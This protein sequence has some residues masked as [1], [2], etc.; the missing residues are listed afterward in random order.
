ML[1][2]EYS[3]QGN[4]QGSEKTLN[5]IELA[6]TD[7]VKKSTLLKDYARCKICGRR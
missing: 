1:S 7:A 5:I 4:K 3:K 6:K 2:G